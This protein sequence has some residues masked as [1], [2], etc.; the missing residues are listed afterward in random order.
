MAN[1]GKSNKDKSNIHALRLKA[2]RPYVKFNYDLRKPLSNYAKRKI[3]SYYDEYLA[4]TARPNHIYRA[5]NPRN[6]KAVQ[7]YSGHALYNGWKVAFVPTADPKAQI[8]VKN[9]V[10]TVKEQYVN[11]KF[12][13]FDQNE[14][15]IDP[16][17]HTREL[18][19][20]SNANRFSIR[21]GE[22]GEYEIPD[23]Y[24]R[25][26]IADE[27]DDL[28][29]KY[30]SDA[31]DNNGNITNQHP[32]YWLMGLAAHT[33]DNQSDVSAY[34]TAKSKA[35]NELKKSNAKNKARKLKT[36]TKK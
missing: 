28:W 34:N 20:S 21:V 14:L 33:F 18:I 36:K 26:V 25:D 5:R 12:L 22:N 16:H 8:R 35:R 31:I 7:T 27:V 11:T 4:L 24:D 32:M 6:L 30:A 23:T 15:L 17:A 2:I 29:D 1:K 3:K 9:G 19:E 13:V 10:V